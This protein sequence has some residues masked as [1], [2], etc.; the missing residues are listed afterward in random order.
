MTEKVAR[1]E[2]AREGVKGTIPVICFSGSL[3]T[4]GLEMKG[5][6]EIEAAFFPLLLLQLA[7]ASRGKHTAA[8]KNCMSVF[9]SR[10]GCVAALSRLQALP[11]HPGLGG[12]GQALQTCSPWLPGLSACLSLDAFRQVA[13]MPYV[14]WYAVLMSCL[15]F[16]MVSGAMIPPHSVEYI[17]CQK[18]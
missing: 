10:E 3:I 17:V 2:L 1:F 11:S 18:I 16:L 9:K 15:F 12:P 5:R 4:K 8:G 6:E 13:L 14:T 7:S